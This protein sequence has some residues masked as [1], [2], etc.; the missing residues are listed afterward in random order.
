MLPKNKNH[1]KDKKLEQLFVRKNLSESRKRAYYRVF[2][3]IQ[4]QFKYTPT[5]L[6][7]IAKE[8]QKP[9]IVD[10]TIIFKELEDRTITEIQYDY[11]FFLL[12]KNLKPSTIRSE[13][14]TYR[15]FLKE[16][17]VQ[18]PKTI[19]IQVHPPLYEEGDLPQ[20]E[21]I[22]KAVQSTNSKRNKAILYFMSSSGIRPIDVRNLKIQTFI[23]GCKYYFDK[24]HLT[25]EDIIES[26]YQHIIPSFYFRP[27]K[28]SKHSN[29]CCT[30]CSH[31]AV[32]SI[33]DYLKT[34]HI[35][36]YDEQLFSSREGGMMDEAS[37]IQMFQRIN[38]KEFGRRKDGERF[39]KPKHL[40]KYFITQCNRHSGDLLKVR[41]L[42]GHS[43][44]NIDR[45]YNEISI[46]AMRRFYTTL[47]PYLS[48]TDT[49]VKDVKT[50]E[51]LLLEEK[52]RVQ[53]RENRKLKEELDDKIADVVHSVLEKYK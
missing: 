38:D 13:L 47:L 25:L 20:K 45:A 34:R 36:S 44:S 52:L 24:E 4:E 8:E 2:E 30:F 11:Y 7:Q 10:N 28:T 22:L 37:F 42:A 32:L 15:S 49:R 51:Y 31:E 17:D 3:T 9:R 48:L 5:Q 35:K 43:I 1:I 29:V 46:P 21:D 16:Y 14:A 12:Q 26:D 6:L 39:F 23:D 53:E 41:L 18:L 19:Q 33:I 40:R 50:Q 27:Q